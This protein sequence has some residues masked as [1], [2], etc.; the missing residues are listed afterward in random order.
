M[1]RTNLIVLLALLASGSLAFLNFFKLEGLEGIKIV[2]RDK[3]LIKTTASEQAPPVRRAGD[4]IKVASFNIQVFGRAK[5][6]KAVV[7]QRLARIVQRF[8]LVAI[9]EI[10]SVQP[11]ILPHFMEYLNREGRNYDFIIGPRVGRTDLKEQFAFVFDRA[12]VEVDRLQSYTIN[13]PDDLLHRP[14]L[15]GWFRVRGPAQSEAFTFTI[16]NVH[17]DPDLVEQETS[18]LKQV[19]QK[20]RGDIRGEDDVILLGDFNADD[21]QLAPLVRAPGMVAAISGVATNTRKTQQYDNILVQ[22]PAVNEYT[23]RSGV[24]DFLREFNLT[25]DEALEIS[26]HLP[27]WAEFSIF[28]G[29]KAGTLAVDTKPSTAGSLGSVP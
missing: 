14:P 2:P 26:D 12:S 15:V 16:V 19:Y 3:S 6:E 21:R 7:M 28:E 13:D 5:L 8:D 29:G 22:L 25:M 10:R 17:T 9:Q 23:G 4:T 20:V 1:K 11:D 27:V 24:F 18:V